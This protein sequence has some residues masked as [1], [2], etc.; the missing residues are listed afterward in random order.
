[1]RNDR[2][3]SKSCGMYGYSVASMFVSVLIFSNVV[4]RLNRF[5]VTEVKKCVMSSTAALRKSRNEAN[6]TRRVRERSSPFDSTFIDRRIGFLIREDMGL[7]QG[8]EVTR[9]HVTSYG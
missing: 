1:M 4:S 3:A 5:S 8:C 7:V 6:A 2:K 9:M